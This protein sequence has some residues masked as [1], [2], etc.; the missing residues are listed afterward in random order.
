MFEQETEIIFNNKVAENSYL[1]GLRAPEVIESARPGQFVMLRIQPGIDPLLRRPFSICG[2][3]AEGTL[4]ILFKIAG[5]GTA[6]L[7]AKKKGEYLSLLGPLGKGFPEPEA[8]VLPVLIGG[9]LGLAPLLFLAQSLAPAEFHFLAGF[10][11]KKETLPFE[12][13]TGPL[14]GLSLS[15]DDGSMGFKG[16]V[17]ALFQKRLASFKGQ[18][19]DINVYTCGPPGMLAKIVRR[20]RAE[21]ISCR[22]SLETHMACGLGACLGCAV[23]AAPETGRT[24]FH[25]C[26]DGPVFDAEDIDWAAIPSEAKN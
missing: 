21:K 18:R 9:G 2:H 8:H 16:P 17:T 11:S 20:C 13:I 1:L 5:R 10:G 19:K 25:V 26:K 6:I 24:Y 3:Q 7:S 23:K 4:L 22:T 12:Q 15:T 14:P